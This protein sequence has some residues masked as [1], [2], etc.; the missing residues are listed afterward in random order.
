MVKLS[1]KP[2]LPLT[3][4]LIMHAFCCKLVDCYNS[5]NSYE[6]NQDQSCPLKLTPSKAVTHFKINQVLGPMF[7]IYSLSWSHGICFLQK[8]KDI[9]VYSTK[10]Q[11]F[12]FLIQVQL[13]C[14]LMPQWRSVTSHLHIIQPLANSFSGH[15]WWKP[16]S[17]RFSQFSQHTWHVITRLTTII[18]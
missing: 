13:Q 16:P 4:D 9:F 12:Q 6:M 14:E 7:N 1:G 5:P 15:Q 2:G 17:M 18:P 11:L 8:F 3:L 10:W